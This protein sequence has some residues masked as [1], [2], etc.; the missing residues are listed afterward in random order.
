LPVDDNAV[1]AAHNLDPFLWHRPVAMRRIGD[2]ANNTV[3][4]RHRH[5]HVLVEFGFA[6]AGAHGDKSGR[7]GVSGER[8]DGVDE[9]ADLAKDPTSLGAV[10]IPVRGR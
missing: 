1:P 3:G 2:G 5:N 6:L 4:E 9:M 10:V 8:T 7:F